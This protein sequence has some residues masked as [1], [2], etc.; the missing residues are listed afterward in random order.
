MKNLARNDKEKMIRDDKHSKSR[1]SPFDKNHSS[2]L[3]F[4]VPWV[5]LDEYGLKNHKNILESRKI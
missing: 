3:Q 4:I 5:L 2:E 1:F